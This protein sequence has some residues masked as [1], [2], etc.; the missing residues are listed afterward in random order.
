MKSRVRPAYYLVLVVYALIIGGLL[1]RE[2]GQARPVSYSLG[3]ISISARQTAGVPGNIL[4]GQGAGFRSL[5]LRYRS[6]Q[7]SIPETGLAVEV[8]EEGTEIPAAVADIDRSSSEISIRLVSGIELRIRE[9]EEENNSY[10][11]SLDFTAADAE[12][13][14]GIRLPWRGSEPQFHSGLPILIASPPGTSGGTV[15]LPASARVNAEF[16]S[17]PRSDSP[18]EILLFNAPEEGSL[19]ESWFRIR[20]GLASREEADRALKE[21][22]NLAYRGWERDR[23]I[24]GAGSWEYVADA[25]PESRTATALLMESLSRGSY[26]STRERL[27]A[28]SPRLIDH[29]SALFLGSVVSPFEQFGSSMEDFMAEV[30]QALNNGDSSIFDRVDSLN[31]IIQAGIGSGEGIQDALSQLAETTVLAEPSS[32][33]ELLRA[34]RAAEFLLEWEGPEHSGIR[35]LIREELLPG[36][37]TTNYGYGIH[38]NGTSDALTSVL[39]GRLMAAGSDDF[40]A[41]LG[42]TLLASF[43]ASAGEFSRTPAGIIRREF[44]YQ[45]SQKLLEPEAL[46][47][48]QPLAG[49]LPYQPRAI[50]LGTDEGWM[51]TTAADVRYQDGGTTSIL[52]FRFP[53]GGIHHFALYGVEPFDQIQMHGIPWK[54]D[55]EFQRYSDGWV[56]NPRT[57]TL[58]FK[59]RHRSERQEIRILRNTPEAAPPATP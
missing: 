33:A 8:D 57:K 34:I 32:P 54:S 13:L 24:P 16:L 55:P 10:I 50:E 27:A 6:F 2:F 9:N 36:L 46:P 53:Q 4:P 25:P 19:I 12:K 26:F 35:Y 40:S 58:F 21:F 37:C 7:L 56:Y 48:L 43:T 22:Y 44:Y 45:N 38:F 30:R 18:Q 17:I 59:I 14:R 31:R 39:A 29:T 28:A 49:E 11:L 51:W 41:A 42:Y 47:R 1:Y 5:T 3:E 15:L 23:W 20:G 52:S